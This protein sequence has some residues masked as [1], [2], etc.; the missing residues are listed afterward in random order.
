MAKSRAA[1]R[2]LSGRDQ[3]AIA[4]SKINAN[5]RIWTELIRWGGL[6]AIA[7]SMVVIVQ[8]LAG[9]MTFADIGIRLLGSLGISTTFAWGTATGG[10][11]YGLR[12]RSLRMKEI[13]RHGNRIRKL[14]ALID[15]RRSTSHLDPK[16]HS[17]DD[18]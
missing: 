15:P 11:V 10:V 8:S 16:G 18:L 4:M 1:K 12:Q 17:P 9:R 7:W 2:E 5:S 14:E 3:A 13:E 6:T